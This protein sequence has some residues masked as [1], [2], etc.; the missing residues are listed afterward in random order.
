MSVCGRWG[1]GPSGR[2]SKGSSRCVGVSRCWCK[3]RRWGMG[4][5]GRLGRYRLKGLLTTEYYARW[6][7]TENGDV[8]IGVDRAGKLIG[9]K[10][11][12]SWKGCDPNLRAAPCKAPVY[13]IGL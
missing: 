4:M 10:A 13:P 9:D 2:W 8:L 11:E 3:G 6:T 12:V 5:R 7:T 1:K